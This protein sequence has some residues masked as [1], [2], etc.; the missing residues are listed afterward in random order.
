[1]TVNAKNGNGEKQQAAAPSPAK[2][3]KKFLFVSFESLSGDLAWQAKKEGNEVKV[4]IKAE[5]DKDVYE[6]FLDRV[7]NWE[8]HTDWADVIVFDDVGFGRIADS[9]RK[10]GK[11]VIGGSE[12][13]DELEED[14][15]FGQHEMQSVG[16]LVL[17]HWDFS[18]FDDAI[19][20]IQ[21]NPGRYV[22]KPS[23]NISSDSKGILFLGKEED[24]KDIIE[25]MEQNKQLWAKKIKRFQLQKM[26][27]GVEVAVGAFFNGD[28]FIYPINVNFEHKRLFPGDIG[29][30]TGEM[31]TLMFW[32][33]AN[34][35]FKTTLLKFKDKLKES[36][37]R[38]Y[39][40]I[41]C[42][43]NAKGIYPLEITSRFGY[44]TISI[45][46]EGVISAWGE[47][48]YNLA[49][50][51]KVE[52]KVSRGFQIGVIVAVPPFPFY[53]KKEAFIYKDLSILF[54]KNNLEGVHL[55]DVKIV[56]GIWSVAGETGYVLVITGSGSTVEEARK[57]VYT[58]L[59]NISLQN[60]YY[61]TD[62]GVRWFTESD[63]LHTW[64]YLH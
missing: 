44:P 48:L 40:D 1:M 10:K 60:M 16:M 52:L 6:G 22:F 59:K 56:N 62:I 51:E 23:G 49:K 42:I 29:P 3:S 28:D 57:E 21:S 19:S 9:L 45:Q 4:Y 5:A 39:I 53:D 33:G 47:F 27:V 41:N 32:S 31:G 26:A 2:F 13:T 8:E 46:M 17:P 20:F 24:G 18:D 25:I 50:K 12:Y 43:A 58:R 55:G 11:L 35:I 14:R 61:R 36:G 7:D 30:Y 54:K 38:G 37:Y 63:K 15:E 34:E 64:G